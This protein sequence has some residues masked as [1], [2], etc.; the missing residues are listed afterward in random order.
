[1]LSYWN[2]SRA[3]SLNHEQVLAMWMDDFVLNLPPFFWLKFD[4]CPV[5]FRFFESQTPA[6]V[7]ANSNRVETEVYAERAAQAHIPCLRRRGGG[8]TV[9]LGP[10]C[11]I[12]TLAFFAQDV[13]QNKIYFDLINRLWIEALETQCNVQG[14]SQNGFSDI[15]FGAQK[16]A[17]TSLFRR[18]YLVVYQGSLLVRM[19]TERLEQL[20][21]HPS[22]EPEYRQGRRHKDFL[23][24]L[25]NLGVPFTAKEIAQKCQTYFQNN[26]GFEIARHA[27]TYEQ[28]KSWHQG[29][30][31]TLPPKKYFAEG[32]V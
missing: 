23:T 12:L 11:V 31:L 30:D 27:Q 25:E 22:Q 15:C 16:V 1:M 17:G 3:L 19:D 9:L 6:I 29:V 21:P 14:L 32:S 2:C 26:A 4:E 24:T 20:L 18:K 7:L 5:L 28:I 8:G 13:F 10:G